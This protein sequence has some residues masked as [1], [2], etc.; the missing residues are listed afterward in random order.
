MAG[1][2][3]R[4]G[5][6]NTREKPAWGQLTAALSQPA[7]ILRAAMVP[8]DVFMKTITDFR[9]RGPPEAEGGARPVSPLRPVEIDML[10]SI[11]R[12]TIRVRSPK[13][14]AMST[15]RDAGAETDVAEATAPLRADDAAQAAGPGG[16]GRDATPG[17]ENEAKEKEKT[18]KSK[19]KDPGKS[20]RKKKRSPKRSRRSSSSGGAGSTS[21][22]RPP[23][24]RVSRRID[25]SDEA[26]FTA[27]GLPEAA[28]LK[29]KWVEN[30]NAGV[31]VES[32]V[33]GGVEQLSALNAKVAIGRPPFCGFPN[34]AP[35]AWS[36]EPGAQAGDAGEC[37]GRL[38]TEDTRALFRC[39]GRRARRG[40]CSASARQDR[41]VNLCVAPPSC[42]RWRREALSHGR[43]AN[44][45]GRSLLSRGRTRVAMGDK[46]NADRRTE[47]GA[48][49]AGKP[50]PVEAPS[51][52]RAD[53]RNSQQGG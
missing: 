43:V 13:P 22:A 35:A 3:R 12:V 41:S 33:E 32:Q 4:V 26:K 1:L 47:Q 21:V 15:S 17:G 28:T 36:H 19:K 16:R 7:Q 10:H 9:P 8:E 46:A 6:F 50:S 52:A 30:V 37:S 31:V 40:I 27:T 18:K 39:D 51:S 53:E 42:K 23:K 11:R 49:A 20:T 48:A 5:A 2:A 14:G 25:Q 34:L 44:R 29:K 24:V 45:E 38:S